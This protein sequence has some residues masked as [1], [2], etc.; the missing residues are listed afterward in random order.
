MEKTHTMPSTRAKCSWKC[1][2][3]VGLGREGAR[4]SLLIQLDL[5]LLSRLGPRVR[6]A[7]PA[8]ANLQKRA[9]TLNYFGVQGLDFCVQGL[10]RRLLPSSRGGAARVLC[11][12]ALVR[13]SILDQSSSL[14]VPCGSHFNRAVARCGRG[15]DQVRPGRVSHEHTFTKTTILL[16]DED[17]PTAK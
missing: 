15:E 16:H 9:T 10:D 5:T 14:G 3:L 6:P 1:S 11:A 7:E 4:S 2:T 8:Q 12:S 17:I 13:S